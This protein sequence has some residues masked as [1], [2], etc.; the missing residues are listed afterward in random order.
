M[1][2]LFKG[3]ILCDKKLPSALKKYVKQS[4]FYEQRNVNM[5]LLY[6]YASKTPEHI[7]A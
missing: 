2:H 7:N 6:D 5:K 3:S 1:K 4:R